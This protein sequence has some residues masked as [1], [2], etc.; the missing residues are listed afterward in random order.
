MTDHAKELAIQAEIVERLAKLSKLYVKTEAITNALA[1]I[2]ALRT[3]GYRGLDEDAYCYFVVGPTNC[4]KSRLFKT[5]CGRPDAEKNGEIWPVVRMSLPGAI[6][7]VKEFHAC[8]LR[9][10][11]TRPFQGAH[12]KSQMEERIVE[13]IETRGVQLI[14]LEETQH[15][16]D[17]KSGMLGYW[18]A[19]LIKELLLDRAKVPVVMSGIEVASQLFLRN[20]QLK[21]RRKGVLHLHAHDWSN[22]V[23]RD[24][25]EVAISA[26]EKAARFPKRVEF[27]KNGLAERI[28]R[29]TDGVIGNLCKLV[30]VCIEMGIREGKEAIDQDLLAVA[31]ASLNYSGREWKNVFTVAVLPPINA[32]DESRTTKL[33]KRAA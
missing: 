9:G 13:R 26:F 14:M 17:K 22:P 23:E 3:T 11:G 12:S 18:G 30:E 25:F 33:H 32:P 24:R 6:Q 21:S 19:D 2:H 1:A 7:N 8:L 29:A 16:L 28:H 15:L 27:V 4:G 5:Y 31:H 10:L 20:S